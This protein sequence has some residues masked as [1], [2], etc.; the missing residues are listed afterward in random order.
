MHV[1]RWLSVLQLVD[2]GTDLESWAKFD[3]KCRHEMVLFQQH[4]CLAIN[5][6]LPKLVCIHSTAGQSTYEV[7]HLLHL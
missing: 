5:L 3:I 6:L 1:I 4:Q 2:F 7:V